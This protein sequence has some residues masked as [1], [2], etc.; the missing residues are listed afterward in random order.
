[1]TL[2][3]RDHGTNEGGGLS[4]EKAE[5]I[6]R[7]REH[8]AAEDLEPRKIVQQSTPDIKNETEEKKSSMVKEDPSGKSLGII[9]EPGS[10]VHSAGD[11]GWKNIPLENLPTRGY[12]YPD[13]L[14]LTIKSAG[15]M[16]IRHWSTMDDSDMLDAD[17]KINFIMEKC[18]RLFKISED[19]NKKT[20]RTPYDWL[21]LKEID[22]L[23]LLFLIQEMTFPNNENKLNVNFTCQN[24]DCPGV[25]NSPYKSKELL[26]PGMINIYEMP[27]E[28]LKFYDSEK[29]KIVIKSQKLGK[30]YTFDL[31]NIGV[32]RK[33]KRY[34]NK[35]K[36]NGEG[37][38]KAFMRIAPYVI[39]DYN[40]LDDDYIEKEQIDSTAWNKKETLLFNWVAE[41]F[42]SGV[43]LTAKSKCRK[44]GEVMEAPLF[45]REGIKVKDILSVPDPL[46]G[47]I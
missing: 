30:S 10:E 31:P 13:G 5:E 21:I 41:K 2:I 9:S 34:V 22:R 47:L 8:E 38:D 37:W 17:D 42:E 1:M 18:V 27:E 33:L 40:A 29:R 7:N 43:F 19:E 32:A 45:F 35:K 4:D 39:T 24:T 3:K 15:V 16:E 20:V 26:T 12:F 44:C 46:D 25:D 11:R 14:E 28:L 23:Y 6:M 36:R